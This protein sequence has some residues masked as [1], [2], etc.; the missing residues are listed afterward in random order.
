LVSILPI[1]GLEAGNHFGGNS[2][3]QSIE[4][5]CTARLLSVR[6]F[7]ALCFGTLGN[8]HLRFTAR[9]R[10]CG[11]LGWRFCR[12]FGFYFLFFFLGWFSGAGCSEQIG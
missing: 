8:I 12:G 9:C 1:G 2:S 10:V 7:G 4:Y 11:F 3:F 6:W 5:V